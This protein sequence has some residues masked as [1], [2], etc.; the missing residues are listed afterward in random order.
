M[1]CIFQIFYLLMQLV[2]HKT[3]KQCPKRFHY[4]L[5]KT[6]LAFCHYV[7]FIQIFKKRS[8]VNI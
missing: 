7:Q 4:E 2:I 8:L 6:Y 1:N 5:H 3:I